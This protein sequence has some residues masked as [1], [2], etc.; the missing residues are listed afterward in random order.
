M[1][2]EINELEKQLDMQGTFD[3]VIYN[4]IDKDDGF[5]MLMKTKDGRTISDYLTISESTRKFRS[6]LCNLMGLYKSPVDSQDF[7]GRYLNI[8]VTKRGND[9]YVS[10]YEK[11]FE[12]FTVES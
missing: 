5:I 3:V 10:H 8:R 9:F 2:F 4:V 7:I 12:P 6:R 11:C 1:K